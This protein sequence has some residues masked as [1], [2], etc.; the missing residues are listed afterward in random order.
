MWSAGID[1]NGIKANL[2]RI[3]NVEMIKKKFGFDVFFQSAFSL[4]EEHS[5]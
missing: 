5:Y 2:M 4:V 1:E 3:F